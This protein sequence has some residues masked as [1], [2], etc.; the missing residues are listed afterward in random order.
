MKRVFVTLQG[1]GDVYWMEGFTQTD[2][3]LDDVY[4][5]DL[6]DQSELEEDGV[7]D[8]SLWEI[9]FI[10]SDVKLLLSTKETPVWDI[11]DEGAVD[12]TK[13]KGKYVK[14]SDYLKTDCELPLPFW[15]TPTKYNTGIVETFCIELEDDEEFDPK[16]LQL[17]K[18]ENEVD[19]I[20]YAIIVTDIMYNGKKIHLEFSEGYK[21]TEWRPFIVDEWYE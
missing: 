9:P 20:P 15:C 3:V 13:E 4:D 6:D 7:L 10:I 12:I 16:K 19:F 1:K 5:Y 11:E 18:Y 2:E 21:S 14:T 8:G 17:I